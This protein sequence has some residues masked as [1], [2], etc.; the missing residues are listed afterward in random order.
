[1]DFLVYSLKRLIA[2]GVYA[3]MSV[4]VSNQAN[5]QT[6]TANGMGLLSICLQLDNQVSQI[7]SRNLSRGS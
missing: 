1:V 6:A 5:S 3:V 2:F 4:N 7:E